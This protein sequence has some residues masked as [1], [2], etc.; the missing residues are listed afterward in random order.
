MKLLIP[1]RV[2]AAV[3]LACSA[4]IAAQTDSTL[5]DDTLP[6]SVLIAMGTSYME[7]TVSAIVKDSLESRGYEV[8][9]V[10]IATLGQQDRRQYRAVILFSAIKASQLTETAR[11]FVQSQAGPGEESNMLVCNI[12]GEAWKPG[13]RGMDA[14]A[15]ATKR[16]RPED[17]AARIVAN[18]E[19]L[20][21]K[22]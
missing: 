2:V 19:S 7:K 18:F 5:P 16:V 21:A 9:I 13:L 3:I 15:S 6:L 10:D 17:V 11:K 1:L 4:P 12:L 14:V 22:K 8:V 20:V